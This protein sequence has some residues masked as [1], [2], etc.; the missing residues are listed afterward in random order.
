MLLSDALKCELALLLVF[1]AVMVWYHRAPAVPIGISVIVF[2]SWFLGFIG[3]LL[4]PAD[5]SDTLIHRAH[6][7]WLLDAWYTVYWSTFFLAWV[8]IPILAEAWQA[9]E[10]TWKERLQSAVRKSLRHYLGIGVGFILFVVYL[11]CSEQT[12][13]TTVSGFL[14]A[15]GNTYGLLLIVLLLG[16]GLI[17]L[18]R[19]LWQTSFPELDL[20]RVYYSAPQVRKRD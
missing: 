2:M 9:G 11:V 3:T 15:W 6:S 18:P 17:E 13:L 19:E 12:S 1:S 20:H 16:H 8:V 5:I 14:M 7:L 4:L 10:L